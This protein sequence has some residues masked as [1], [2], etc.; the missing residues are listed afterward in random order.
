MDLWW[1][2]MGLQWVVMHR[3]CSTKWSESQVDLRI[4]KHSRKVVLGWGGCWGVTLYC[5]DLTGFGIP[6]RD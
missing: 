3:V 5:V 2:V 6:L 1:V 4:R